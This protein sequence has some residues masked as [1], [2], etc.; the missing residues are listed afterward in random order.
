MIY[1][2]R[3]LNSAWLIILPCSWHCFQ[4]HFTQHNTISNVRR[5]FQTSVFFPQMRIHF[6]SHLFIFKRSFLFLTHGR[7]TLILKRTQTI[8]NHI[9]ENYSNLRI[10]SNTQSFASQV[11]YSQH[12]Y[13]LFL[14]LCSLLILHFADQVCSRFRVLN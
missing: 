4:R 10:L 13:W 9:I 12:F 14:H 8:A 2:T 6:Q 1:L 5:C 7:A 3:A 11:E